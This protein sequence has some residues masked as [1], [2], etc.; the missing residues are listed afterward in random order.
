MTGIRF[1]A[2]YF[3]FS[4]RSDWYIQTKPAIDSS[5]RLHSIPKL[6]K[7]RHDHLKCIWAITTE[8]DPHLL[9]KVLFD[10][11]IVE[12]RHEIIDLY[13]LNIWVPVL[14]VNRE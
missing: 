8:P 13:F 4:G 5:S 1:K 14:Y 2:W 10:S 6:L 7:Y 12:M 11:G 9:L 3:S